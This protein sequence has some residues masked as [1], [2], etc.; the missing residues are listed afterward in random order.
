[1]LVLAGACKQETEEPWYGEHGL[2]PFGGFCEVRVLG[3]LRWWT[4][5]SP[6]HAYDPMIAKLVRYMGYDNRFDAEVI[7]PFRPQ[8]DLGDVA[9]ELLSADLPG[10]RDAGVE[11]V[12][13]MCTDGGVACACDGHACRAADLA[14]ELTGAGFV[15]L[16]GGRAIPWGSGLLS[17]VGRGSSRQPS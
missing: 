9:V 3:A 17:Y 2:C 4:E 6:T 13:I 16:Q 12:R 15:I 14:D 1:M 10:L 8:L 7:S 5:R 11:L